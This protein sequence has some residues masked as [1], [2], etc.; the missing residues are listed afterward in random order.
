MIR[1]QQIRERTKTSQVILASSRIGISANVDDARA[2]GQMGP[3]QR[4]AAAKASKHSEYAKF[5][6]STLLE[7]R[8]S[9]SVTM[10]KRVNIIHL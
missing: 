1:S 5:N 3:E 9:A 8:F 2:E 4:Q 7:G 6:I 10:E